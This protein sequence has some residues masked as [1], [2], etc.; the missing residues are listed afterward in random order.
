MATI[1]DARPWPSSPRPK[2]RENTKNTLCRNVV[3]YGFC[4]HEKDGCMYN[5]DTGRGNNTLA[6]QHGDKRR[7]NV[8]SPSFT[9]TQL[10]SSAG[11][12]GFTPKAAS[13]VP[14]T[15]R[16]T[17]SGMNTPGLT[18]QRS[19]EWSNHDEI[20]EFVPQGFNAGPSQ[21]RSQSSGLGLGEAFNPYADNIN[22][23]SMD[24]TPPSQHINPYAAEDTTAAVGAAYYQPPAGFTQPL[25]H[26]LYAPLG[27][28]RENLLGYQRNVHDFFIS[29]TLRQ[30]MQKKS[31]ATLQVLPNS[32]L[33]ASI[34]HFHSLVP[35][36]TNNQRSASVY[37]YSTWVYKATSGKDG[38][39]YA[40]RRL[41]GFRLT[42]ERAVRTVQ[43][44]KKL[45][46]G[47][48]VTVHDCFT[49]R[50][51]GDSSLVF[52][53]DY[54][55][56]AK[57]LAE[58]HF[59]YSS[60]FQRSRTATG[61]ILEPQLWS[62][63]CQLAS[64]LKAIHSSGLAART[65]IPSKVL[66]TDK[67]RIRLSG[68]AIVDVVEANDSQEMRLS[69][70]QQDDMQQLGHLIISLA[71]HTTNTSP[72]PTKALESLAR[73]YSARL[74]DTLTSLISDKPPD[75]DTLL[76]S[77]ADQLVAQFD[78]TLHLEDTLYSEL[79]RELEN[80]RIS[81]LLMKLGFIN[82]R[83]EMSPSNLE[84]PTPAQHNH[85]AGGQTPQHPSLSS[86]HPH[87][88]HLPHHPSHNSS[89]ASGLPPTAW[90]ETG[91]RYPLK[92]LR[93]YIFH[94]VDNVGRPV[95]DMGHVL[96]CL[97]KL[98]AGS[99]EKVALV[100]RDEQ[101]VLVISW[102]ELKRMIESAW[103][104]VVQGGKAVGTRR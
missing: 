51:F 83:P 89:P 67:N 49:T 39:T 66:L 1:H 85:L 95:V 28:H 3:I 24:S 68:N 74:R 5:H 57:T 72:N 99:E 41:E 78:N 93:D 53:M 59:A 58:Q 65:I 44:W 42:N 90:S 22:Y 33:P 50:A 82:E 45:S 8:E 55:P 98:D 32:T 84:Y 29:E 80:S 26:H 13:A 11:K 91:E 79:S 25:Q 64:A 10:D 96:S 61:L 9:P 19:S 23:N 81:R 30:D 35:L 47:N 34:E 4:R 71:S 76:S 6:P 75:I 52:V 101:N 15:P 38:L 48:V 69:Q 27:P 31:D 63:I 56:L 87:A 94:Q 40:L 100:T 54:H 12:T 77:I 7:L 36:D 20:P 21:D 104:E 37:G 14:F 92:L 16:S 18:S 102:K 17:N 97:N 73:S 46:N 60:N 103:V 88:Q 62:Y 43:N 2:G 70:Q 86:A